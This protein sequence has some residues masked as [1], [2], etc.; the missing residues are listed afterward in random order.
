LCLK[1]ISLEKRKNLFYDELRKLNWPP[2]EDS[3]KIQRA[4]FAEELFKKLENFNLKKGLYIN[5]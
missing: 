3:L 4:N 5:F 2:Q 1:G